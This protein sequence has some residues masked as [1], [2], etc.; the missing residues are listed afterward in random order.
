MN[1]ARPAPDPET[2]GEASAEGSHLA[3]VVPAPS[4]AAPVEKVARAAPAAG[5][6]F[7]G[8]GAGLGRVIALFGRASVLV[9]G[10]VRTRGERALADFQKR[11]RHSR[12]RAYA[13]GAF[14]LL[15]AATLLGQLYEA[16][17]LGAYVR[18]EKVDLPK[19]TTVF[20]RNDSD[21]PWVGLKVTLNGKYEYERL[22]LEPYQS[23]QVRVDR[24]TSHGVGS[25]SFAP[26]TTEA[27]L[28][29]IECDR[30]RFEKEIR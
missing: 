27:R 29:A 9:F 18:V 12:L 24:F 14:G 30:G 8:S 6:P 20:I 11:D 1:E 3:L 16:N 26:V 17:S 7:Q 5:R 4:D 15:A 2:G 19:A 21:K 13:F 23:F 28:I 10:L 25:L 22:R